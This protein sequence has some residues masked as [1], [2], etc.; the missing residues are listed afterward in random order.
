MKFNSAKKLAAYGVGVAVAVLVLS[1]S[2]PINQSLAA[3]TPK[4]VF[5]PKPEYRSVLKTDQVVALQFGTLLRQHKPTVHNVDEG[6]YLIH[7]YGQ[8]SAV[9]VEGETG[10]AVFDVGDSYEIGKAMLAAIREY[11]DKPIKAVIYSHFHFDHIFGG[12]AWIEAADDDVQIIA[13]ES[14]VRYLNERVSALAPRTDWGLSMQFGMH[15]DESCEVGEGPLCSGVHGIQ[16]PRVGSTK[17]HKR[18]VIYPNRT[19][20]DRLKLDNIG[21]DIELIHVPSET[22]DN[23]IMWIPERKAIATGDALTPTLPP[24]FTAR[25][26]RVRDPEAWIKAV[27]LMRS[28]NPEHVI[29]S[30]GPAYS[31]EMAS[32]ILENYHDALA[33]MY[34]QTVRLINQGKGPEEIASELKLPSHLVNYPY[35]GQWYNDL[36]TNVRGIYSYLVG[37]YNDVAEMPLLNPKTEDANMIALAGGPEAYLE[38]LQQ[39]YDRGDYVWVARAASHLIR[40]EPENQAVKNLKASALRVLAAKTRAGSHRHFYLQHAAAL[41]GL[42]EIPVAARFTREDVSTVPVAALVNQLPFRLNMDKAKG[43]RQHFTI[44]ISDSDQMFDVE[45]RNG[46]AEVATIQTTS[47]ADIT[48]DSET[49]RLFYIGEVALQQGFTDKKI[50]GDKAKAAA[51]FDVFDWPSS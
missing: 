2:L 9:V 49:F 41:E 12:K 24:I 8:G 45:L 37:H 26:Q 50:A 13:H 6:V 14:I 11:T 25:G 32:Q 51:F 42:I 30:H 36:Q 17:G 18:H 4:P 22:P 47:A 31:G 35:L 20:R 1:M 48:M 27:N 19:F 33:F 23:I 29:P 21:L 5:E 44:A 16:F 43:K 46:V 15:L 34:H 40:L 38:R 7:G 28:L 39:A 10:L 3:L